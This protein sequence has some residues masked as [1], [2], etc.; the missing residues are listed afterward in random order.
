MIFATRFEVMAAFMPHIDALDEVGHLDVFQGIETLVINGEGDML[1]P[2]AHSEEIV[3][4]IPG[5]EHVV[6]SHAGHLIML[7]HPEIVTQQLLMLVDRA[8]RARDEGIAMGRKPRVRRLIT[9][10]TTRRRDAKE[11]AGSA[12]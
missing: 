8:Q 11:R 9:E 10:L 12:S 5:A 4:R 6:V 1:T 3:R 7:E 2:P